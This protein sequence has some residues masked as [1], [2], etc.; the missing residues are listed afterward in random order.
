VKFEDFVPHGDLPNY[1][2][3]ADI[4]VF[5][6]SCENMPNTLIEAMAFGLPIACSNRGPMPEVLQDGGEYF[7]PES[8]ESILNAVLRIMLDPELRDFR[9]SR[10]RELASRYSWSRCA[11]ETY[12]F[13]VD[14]HKIIQNKRAKN[15]S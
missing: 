7:D 1:L 9:E 2:A 4:F 6:S 11:S 3:Q 13:I 10:A 14:T 8:S 5:A 15:G 12:S